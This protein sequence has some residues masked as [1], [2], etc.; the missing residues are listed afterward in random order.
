MSSPFV[1]GEPELS[2]HSSWEAA[3][4]DLIEYTKFKL[5]QW[6]GA[7]KKL[8]NFILDPLEFIECQMNS[9]GFTRREG[10]FTYSHTESY[11]FTQGTL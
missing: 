2:R 11:I 4:D 5:L 7:K 3:L 9:T 6:C 8:M 10:I 1:P